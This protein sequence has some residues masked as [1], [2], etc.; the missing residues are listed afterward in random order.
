MI[1]HY[2]K[3]VGSGRLERVC[4]KWVVLSSWLLQNSIHV[5]N[6]TVENTIYGFSYD[7]YMHHNEVIAIKHILGNDEFICHVTALTLMV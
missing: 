5:D 4:L 2:R 7:K 6:S 1:M 3:W